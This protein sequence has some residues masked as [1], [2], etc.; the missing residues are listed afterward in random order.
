MISYQFQ[1]LETNS[2]FSW[3][4]E[5]IRHHCTNYRQFH[6]C[7]LSYKYSS[8]HFHC[9]LKKLKLDFAHHLFQLDSARYHHHDQGQVT[10]RHLL[11]SHPSPKES[12]A[13]HQEDSLD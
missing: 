9:C 13:L 7:C 1:H 12:D 6:C 3:H 2:K 4:S 11:S 8:H 5:T 10:N